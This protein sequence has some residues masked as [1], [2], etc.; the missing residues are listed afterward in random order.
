MA[1]PGEVAGGLRRVAQSRSD[2]D[3]EGASEED[4]MDGGGQAGLAE[5]IKN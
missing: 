2:S 3:R 5:M 4:I 1:N